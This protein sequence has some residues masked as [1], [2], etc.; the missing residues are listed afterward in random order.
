MQDQNKRVA[1]YL[2]QKYEDRLFKLS[3]WYSHDFGSYQEVLE[4]IGYEVDEDEDE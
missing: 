2:N 1:D 4:R 3:K